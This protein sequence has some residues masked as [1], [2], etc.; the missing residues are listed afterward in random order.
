MME[1]K[2]ISRNK[3]TYR[4]FLSVIEQVGTPWAEGWTARWQ[5]PD[6]PGA[7]LALRADSDAICLCERPVFGGVRFVRDRRALCGVVARDHK[8]SGSKQAPGW[9]GLMLCR[10]SLFRFADAGRLDMDRLVEASRSDPL[11]E[12]AADGEEILL[13]TAPMSA[14]AM[15]RGALPSPSHDVAPFDQNLL[16]GMPAGGA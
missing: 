10:L 6:S 14:L 1:G 15:A 3:R 16:S 7:Y 8:N 13:A 11:L 5:S 2:V 12:S 4:D 9:L